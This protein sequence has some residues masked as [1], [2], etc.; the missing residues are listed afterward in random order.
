MQIYTHVHIQ[1]CKHMHMCK[2]IYNFFNNVGYQIITIGLLW[3]ETHLPHENLE[4]RWSIVLAIRLAVDV[5]W[6]L[7]SFSHESSQ[8][9][10]LS[11]LYR[12]IA[13]YI[14]N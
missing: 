7:L 3:I 12:Y 6:H 4:E 14:Q 2:Y 9:I 11:V 1:I 13:I 10:F 5:F 8:L